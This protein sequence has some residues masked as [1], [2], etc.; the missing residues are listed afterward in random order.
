[1]RVMVDLMGGDAAPDAPIEG[2]RQALS[3]EPELSLGLVGS[4][5]SLK[6]VI[7][8]LR[9][10]PGSNHAAML[11]LMIPVDGSDSDWRCTLGLVFAF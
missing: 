1:M 8:V 9:P 3:R 11:G 4:E 10:L 7:G 2:A 6:S 5:S